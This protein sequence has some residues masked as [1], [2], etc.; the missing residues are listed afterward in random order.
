MHDAA[1]RSSLQ[2]CA[3]VPQHS[4]LRRNRSPAPPR[5][6][7]RFE[8]PRESHSV[9]IAGKDESLA[10]PLLA[11]SKRTACSCAADAAQGSLAGNKLAWTLRQKRKP[12]PLAYR[13]PASLANN[14]LLPAAKPSDR[15]AVLARS[16]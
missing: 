2:L 3:R 16:S 15:S 9:C 8:P 1:L 4:P 7:A 14:A 10:V 5:P 11:W 13:A 12:H 6:V